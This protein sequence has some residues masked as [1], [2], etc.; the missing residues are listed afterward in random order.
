MLNQNFEKKSIILIQNEKKLS[1]SNF[2]VYS[3]EVYKIIITVPIP[4]KQKI[5]SITY[6]RPVAPYQFLGRVFR[7]ELKKLD[8][9]SYRPRYHTRYP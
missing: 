1:N 3:M 8:K 4:L 6:Y 2:K 7:V 9:Y 5:F